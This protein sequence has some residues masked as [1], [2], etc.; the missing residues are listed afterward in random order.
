MNLTPSKLYKFPTHGHTAHLNN[1]LVMYLG[2]AHIH[3]DDG[4]CENFRIH[5]VGVTT[6]QHATMDYGDGYRRLHESR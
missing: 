3:R 5:V 1:K 6:L 2:E 4:G